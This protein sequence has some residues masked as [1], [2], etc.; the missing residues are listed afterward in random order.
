M[1]QELISLEKDAPA[2]RRVQ[3]P[4]E[5]RVVAFAQVGGLH[6]RYERRAASR[7]PSRL[8]ATVLNTRNLLP[9]TNRTPTARHVGNRIPD[10][11]SLGSDPAWPN[12]CRIFFGE[13]QVMSQS[14][15][16][17]NDTAVAPH[18]PAQKPTVHGFRL[19]DVRSHADP[20]QITLWFHHLHVSWE[21][22]FEPGARIRV[23]R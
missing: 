9:R 22:N 23:A 3:A 8:A 6:H 17:L 14:E 21:I 4:T 13:P 10:C 1:G 5:G 11:G 19:A 15:S 12:R 20:H 2:P 18:G 7:D 16:Q